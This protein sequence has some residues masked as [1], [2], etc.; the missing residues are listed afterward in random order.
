MCVVST[1]V[2]LDGLGFQMVPIQDRLGAGAADAQ[3]VRPAVGPLA[4]VHLQLEG[5][6][7]WLVWVGGDR[8]RRAGWLS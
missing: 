7:A 3:L 6:A 4:R 5:V 1:P 2:P 8:D